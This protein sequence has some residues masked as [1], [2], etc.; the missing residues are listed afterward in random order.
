MPD[1]LQLSGEQVPDRLVLVRLG[2]STLADAKLGDICRRTFVQCGLFGFSVF[3]LGP[4]GYEELARLAPIIP[5]RQ[6][7]MEAP[8]RELLE[9]GFPILPTSD[10]P[11][12]TVVLAESTT[13]QFD[14]VRRHFSEPLHNPA[15]RMRP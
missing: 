8:S 10:H 1:L 14:R 5:V 7:V 13:L 15:W 6:W 11:H 12:W 2:R 3:A 9:D 4:G